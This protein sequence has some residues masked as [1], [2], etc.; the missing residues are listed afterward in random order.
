MK[1]RQDDFYVEELLLIV[2]NFINGCY[3]FGLRKKD[4]AKA[5]KVAEVTIKKYA[6]KENIP[7]LEKMV[8]LLNYF[9]ISFD[10]ILNINCLKINKN[11][12]YV[13]I[14]FDKDVIISNIKIIFK[15]SNK[16]KTM[17]AKELK[18]CDN[19]FNAILKSE[20]IPL[21]ISIYSLMKIYNKPFEWFFKVHK[22]DLISESLELSKY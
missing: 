21:F 19:T 7:S 11:N 10:D 9:K 13:P 17:M 16:T 8:N 1:I 5:F 22:D 3:E 4:L 20:S 2:S 12:N 18:I 15:S 6:Y 14:T